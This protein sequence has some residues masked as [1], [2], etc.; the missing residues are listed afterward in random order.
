MYIQTVIF[1]EINLAVS[2]NFLYSI[3]RLVKIIWVPSHSG[4]HQNEIADRLARRGGCG[5]TSYE[6][7]T[8]ADNFKPGPDKGPSYNVPGPKYQPPVP[9]KLGR[10]LASRGKQPDVMRRYAS[11]GPAHKRTRTI[12]DF[13]SHQASPSRHLSHCGNGTRTNFIISYLIIATNASGRGLLIY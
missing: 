7:V 9:L 13:L 4:V 5:I 6:T 2:T 1:I 12:S 10:R 3:N 11:L 8:L